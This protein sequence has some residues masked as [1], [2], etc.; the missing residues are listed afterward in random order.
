MLKT[1]V[2]ADRRYL[3]HFGGRAHPERPERAEVMIAELAKVGAPQSLTQHE[4]LIVGRR[5]G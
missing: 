3:K 5:D 4:P 2:V 1:G